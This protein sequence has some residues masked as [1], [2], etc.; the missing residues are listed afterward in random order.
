MWWMMVGGA[1]AG[2][3][4]NKATQNAA[5]N[6]TR[7][8]AL[9]AETGNRTRQA[10]NVAQAA[11]SG[12]QRFVQ[13]LNNQRAL[14]AGGDAQGA[15]EINYR[16]YKDSLGSQN[17]SRQVGDSEQAGAAAAAQAAAGIEGSVVDMVN[18]STALRSALVNDQLIKQGD[19]IDYDHARRAG[20]IAAETIGGLDNSLILDNLDYN[21][22]FAQVAPRISSFAAAVRG[23]F[24]YAGDTIKSQTEE[25]GK[26][27]GHQTSFEVLGKE[28]ENTV[29]QIDGKVYSERGEENQ[30]KFKQDDPDDTLSLWD[31]DYRDFTNDSNYSDPYRSW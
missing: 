1:V 26:E 22:D 10:R 7:L 18:T 19:M 5:A 2:A 4:G 20:N 17:L 25:P 31:K 6:N 27:G 16:R 21:V 8:S 9:N 11:Q 15:N 13:S 29:L 28:G 12:L 14:K 23:A 30:F 3:Y 24:P